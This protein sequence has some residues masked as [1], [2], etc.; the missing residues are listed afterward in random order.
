MAN[1][2]SDEELEMLTEMLIGAAC[3][4]GVVA[5]AGFIVIG[6]HNRLV[7]LA[8]RCD[9]AFAD[10]DVQLRNRHDLIPSLVE[11]V[12]GFASHERAVIDSLMSA[13]ASAIRA[14]T[15][16]QQLQAEALVSVKLGQVLASAEAYPEV[17]GSQHF[18]EL[19]REI[20]DVEHKIAAARRF[21]N[22]AVSE[23][24]ASLAQFPNNLI[25]GRT[26]AQPRRYFDLGLDRVFAEEAP[27]VKF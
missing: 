6:S 14:S 22:M 18:M 10:I 20:S 4:G 27:V 23:H 5:A 8:Q 19:R 12:R 13:R 21:L 7:T 2:C 15:P 26:G 9:Q 3:A 17:N 24:N 11:T 1:G 25:V 16:E